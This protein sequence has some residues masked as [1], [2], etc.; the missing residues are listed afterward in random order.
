[1]TDILCLVF[2]NIIEKY[3]IPTFETVKIEYIEAFNT[4]LIKSMGIVY[5]KA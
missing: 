1:M 3:V 2:S 5:V 4:F